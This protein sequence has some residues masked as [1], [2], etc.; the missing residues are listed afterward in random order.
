MQTPRAE[1]LTCF[2]Y[3]SSHAS[4]ASGHPYAGTLAVS[5]VILG[6]W[7]PDTRHWVQQRRSGPR[8]LTCDAGVVAGCSH[9]QFPASRAQ[10]SSPLLQSAPQ[11]PSGEL[12]R[13]SWSRGHCMHT[14]GRGQGTDRV[15]SCCTSSSEDPRNPQTCGGCPCPRAA[16]SKDAGAVLP[17]D[18][19]WT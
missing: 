8:G 9:G 18:A 3:S 19:L 17:V 7:V 14:E 4:P 13:G 6:R 11:V 1:G 10:G 12:A 15:Q 5:G 16:Q 2:R